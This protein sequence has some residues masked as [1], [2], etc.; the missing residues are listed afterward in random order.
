MSKYCRRCGT[1][2]D[3]NEKFCTECGM[4]YAEDDKGDVTEN[5]KRVSLVKCKKPLLITLVIIILIGVLGCFVIY[6]KVTDYLH[7]KENQKAAQKVVNLIDSLNG[8]EITADSE[9]DL[10]RIRLEYD[11]LSKEQKELVVNY[12]DLEKAYER[13]EESKNQKVADE[14]ISAIDK[15]D[16][17]NLTVSDTSVA[18]L[19]D[20]YNQLSDSQKELV[21]NIDKLEECE[22]I[23]QDKKAEEE[24]K[25]VKEQESQAQKSRI[26]ET[27]ENL[28]FF[29]GT[30][31]DFGSHV[32]QYQGMVETAIKNSIS[33]SDYF[34]DVNNVYMILELRVMNDD[35]LA[36]GLTPY[37]QMYTITFEGPSVTG[38]GGARYLDCTVSSPDGV[39]L[40]YNEIS[41]Y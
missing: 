26:L 39:N 21:T 16:K 33:L 9:N 23:V 13:V 36:N 34:G 12:S 41:Y 29:E 25:K 38:T 18:E 20:K 22:Q 17:D 40:V 32:N 30:W 15:I 1:E 8:K 5:N 31:G 27:F 19:R 28:K 10:D 14:I 11:S 6:S 7:N 35:V 3:D 4:K 2:L 37:N 24:E